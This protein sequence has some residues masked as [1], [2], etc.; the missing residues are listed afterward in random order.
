MKIE[1][2]RSVA[3]DPVEIDKEQFGMY[4]MNSSTYRIIWHKG[5]YFVFHDIRDWLRLDKNQIAVIHIMSDIVFHKENYYKFILLDV[6]TADLK[7]SNEIITTDDIV[8]FPV[9]KLPHICNIIVKRIQ[10]EKN[11]KQRT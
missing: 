4:L 6:K 1:F 9:V 7:F 8:V 11:A 5:Y 3:N 10:E 2:I